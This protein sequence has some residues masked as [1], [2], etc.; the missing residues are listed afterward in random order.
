[1]PWVGDAS[2]ALALACGVAFSIG[3]WTPTALTLC[4]DVLPRGGVG[5]MAGLSGTGAGVGNITFTLITGWLVDRGSYGAVFLIAGLLPLTGYA[6]LTALVGEV[7]LISL[8]P[9][10]PLRGAP[11]VDRVPDT[12]RNAPPTS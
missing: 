10:G 1:M 6:V 11:I 9:T 2:V 7:T 4:A 12:D 3:L 5:T 8:E